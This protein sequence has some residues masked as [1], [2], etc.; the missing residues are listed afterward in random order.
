MELDRV[1]SEIVLRGD[2]AVYWFVTYLCLL[3]NA[4]VGLGNQ[5]LAGGLDLRRE[6]FEVGE[7]AGGDDDGGAF[8]RQQQRR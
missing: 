8:F 7:R 4:D 5:R 2:P 3:L 6:R 1:A